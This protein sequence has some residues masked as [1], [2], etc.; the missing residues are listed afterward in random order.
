V[1]CFEVFIKIQDIYHKQQSLN[2]A[3]FYVALYILSIVLSLTL[4]SLNNADD[5]SEQAESATEDLNDEDFDEG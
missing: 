3:T 4:S 2:N 5:Y 1:F